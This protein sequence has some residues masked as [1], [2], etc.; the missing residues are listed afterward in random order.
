MKSKLRWIK[1]VLVAAVALVVLVVVI[2]WMSGMFNVKTSPGEVARSARTAPAEKVVPVQ[3]RDVPR[4]TRAVGTIRAVHETTVGSR[5]MARVTAV[6][7]IAGQSVQKDDVLIELDRDELQARID[8]AKANVNAANAQLRQAESDLEKVTQ[9]VAAGSA[10][11][12]ELTDAQRAKEVAAANL[13]VAQEAATEAQTYLQY[14]TIRSPINGVVIDKQIEVGDLA[15]P[16]TPLVTLYDPSRLQLVAAVPER[17]AVDLKVDQEV[18]VEVDAVDLKCEAR[19][20]EIVHQAD[21]T[22]RSLL[23]KVTGPCPPNVYSG[24]FGRLLL[25]EGVQ[26]QLLVPAD[27]VRQ[28]GQLEMVEV[29]TASAD[30]A[31]AIKVERRLVRTG[32][33]QNDL[34]EVL[35]GL[36][37]NDRVVA[38]YGAK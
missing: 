13:Q 21:P 17:L 36:D 27:A 2:A 30:K 29:A 25:Q 22:S 31:G 6:N 3:Q 33:R 18:G 4:I 24:M 12:R 26:T 32:A 37:P 19:I 38:P 16:E 35:A 7:V 14:A 34:V 15:K 10:T 23:V 9:L 5:L 11:Q 8:Q 20:S 28:V 1:T